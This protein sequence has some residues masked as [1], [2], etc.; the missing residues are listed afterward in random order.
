VAE[1][2][3]FVP[4]GREVTTERFSLVFATP[5]AEYADNP[6]MRVHREGKPGQ[7][8]LW[9]EVKPGPRLQALLELTSRERKEPRAPRVSPRPLERFASD[10]EAHVPTL[11]ALRAH[12]ENELSRGGFFLVTEA[13]PALR[14]RVRLLLTLP[15]GEVLTFPAEVVHQLSQ[16]VRGVGLQLELSPGALEPIERL[17]A[18]D[19]RTPHVL[20]VE[21]EAIWRSTLQRVFDALGVRVTMARDGREGLVK[22]IDQYFDLDLVVLDLHMPELDGRGLIERVRRLGGE[23][24]FKMF[25]FSAASR[26]ELEPLDGPGQA[27]EVFSKLEPLDRLA[28]RLASELGKSWPPAQAA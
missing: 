25:L 6:A 17:L 18:A 22:L 23:Q 9:L 1:G 5:D 4:T 21:D 27:T 13:S 3:L 24:A 19:Q 11:E 10:L 14:S 12:F 16:P 26:A 20:V 28:A 8:G 2:A 7:H 15:N